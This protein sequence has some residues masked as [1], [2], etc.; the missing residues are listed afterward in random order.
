MDSFSADILFILGLAFV[1]F[2][3]MV[4]VAI[5][6]FVWIRK[7]TREYRIDRHAPWYDQRYDPYYD[8]RDPPRY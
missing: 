8:P 5:V 1:C 3:I 2:L 6:G 7:R 4:A